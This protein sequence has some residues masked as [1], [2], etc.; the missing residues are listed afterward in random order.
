VAELLGSLDSA[1]L[2]ANLAEAREKIAAAAD[3]SGRRAR[4]VELLAATKYIPCEL[5]GA[6]VDG[7]VTLVG[8][9]TAQALVE[10]HSRWHDQLTF[11]FIGHVQSRKVREIIPR[12]R[13][14]HSL[15]SASALARIER[16]AEEPARALVEVNIAGEASKHGVSPAEV[17]RFVEAAG[18]MVVFEGLM[19]MPPLTD[20]QESVRS[21]FSQL[22]EL[23]LRLGERWAPRHPFVR[24]SM[25]TSQDF[26]V[27]VEEGATIVRLG[28]ALYS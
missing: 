1:R 14:I 15:E 8:E 7:G 9:N 25:G 23:S 11:D 4:N 10:K 21:Y 16:L 13:L 24:L 12:A 5:F 18:E 3:R 6:L 2:A 26:E 17:E 27:A 22:R 28:Q 20:D 19:T